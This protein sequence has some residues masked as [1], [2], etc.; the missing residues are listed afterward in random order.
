MPLLEHRST[1]TRLGP[2]A[3]QV[4]QYLS[5]HPEAQDTVEGITEWWLLENSIRRATI[6]VQQAL[7]QLQAEGLVLGRS[8]GDRRV[9]Y[10]LN[11]RK[12]R[13]VALLLR[14]YIGRNEGPDRTR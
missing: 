8:G 1:P 13:A 11:P 9:H 10:R 2:I 3:I 14:R 12:R 7:A 5:A 4:L 6:E